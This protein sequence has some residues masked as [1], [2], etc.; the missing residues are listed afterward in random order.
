MEPGHEKWSRDLKNPW[1]SLW[2]S[3]ANQ[4]AGVAGAMTSAEVRRQQNAVAE[5]AERAW[6]GMASASMPQGVGSPPAPARNTTTRNTTTRNTPAR[7]ATTRNTPAKK[8]R[9][10]ARRAPRP[11]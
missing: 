8:R 10:K 7:N 3:A 9:A 5:G 4:W 1:M 2:L 6:L 11:R